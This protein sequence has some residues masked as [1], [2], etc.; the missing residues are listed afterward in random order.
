VIRKKK[1]YEDMAEADE[2]R[3]EAEKKRY[4]NKPFADIVYSAARNSIR[5]KS[6]CL[7]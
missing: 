1:P 5:W 2:K 3:Y 4:H 6:E 7:D